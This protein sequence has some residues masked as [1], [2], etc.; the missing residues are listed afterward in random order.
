MQFMNICFKSE[1]VTDLFCDFF[2]LIVKYAGA[3]GAEFIIV[4]LGVY[5]PKTTFGLSL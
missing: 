3:G 1:N 5:G 4:A 2:V